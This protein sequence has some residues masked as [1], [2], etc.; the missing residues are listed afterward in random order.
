[1]NFSIIV[2]LFI[3]FIALFVCTSLL[4]VFYLSDWH[5]HRMILLQRIQSQQL[6]YLEH[7]LSSFEKSK[8]FSRVFAANLKLFDRR[9][10]AMELTLQQTLQGTKDCLESLKLSAETLQKKISK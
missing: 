6:K 4:F 10:T 9:M 3:N 1:M 2:T 8:D 5:T 7:N